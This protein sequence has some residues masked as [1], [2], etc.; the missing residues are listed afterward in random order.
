M[1]DRVA[2]PLIAVLSVVAVGLVAFLL[3][4]HTPGRGGRADVAA[5]PALNATLNGTSAVLL[6]VGWIAILRRPGLERKFQHWNGSAP[7][8][9]RT[10]AAPCPRA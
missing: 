3:L 5:L 6:V 7:R 2:F 10:A 1:R 9:R 4:G 8:F